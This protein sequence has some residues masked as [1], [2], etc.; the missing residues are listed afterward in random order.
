MNSSQKSFLYFTTKNC[1]D[2]WH[3]HLPRRAILDPWF[4][5]MQHPDQGFIKNLPHRKVFQVQD[6]QQHFYHIKHALYTTLK[7]RMHFLLCHPLKKEFNILQ[8]LAKN[9]ISSIQAIGYGCSSS[10]EIL[11]TASL[12]NCVTALEFWHTIALTSPKLQ[13]SF[14]QSFIQ[15]LK[16][17]W[18]KNYLHNDFHP[19]NILCKK[20]TGEVYLVDP[21]KLKHTHVLQ[22]RLQKKTFCFALLFLANRLT[23]QQ[24]IKMLLQIGVETTDCAAAALLQ[25]TRKCHANIFWHKYAKR[26]KKVLAGTSQY[27][28]IMKHDAD[29]LHIRNTTWHTSQSFQPE[30]LYKLILPSEEAQKL[31]LD[32]ILT[33]KK[34]GINP[35]I[36]WQQNFSKRMDILY[37]KN[38]PKNHR[39][40]EAHQ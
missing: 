27:S 2:T 6:N 15:L 40:N 28:R 36:M 10:E 17:L 26:V 18:Q 37:Y 7:L 13:Q 33:L 25:H 16:N 23:N 11:I 1:S 8:E 12:P 22:K 31:W 30:E 3:W 38:H 4:Q 35:P 5:N 19:E 21:Y 29:N 24:L 32:S 9:K 39:N 34:N 14:I 20:N